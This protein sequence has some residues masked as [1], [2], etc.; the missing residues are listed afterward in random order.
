MPYLGWFPAI[1]GLFLLG[2]GLARVRGSARPGILAAS[3]PMALLSLAVVWF[4]GAREI[5]NGFRAIPLDGSP[6]LDTVLE[7]LEGVRVLTS[8]GTIGCLALLAAV[9][10][11][12]I[13]MLREPPRTKS[14][15]SGGRSTILVLGAT[16]SVIAGLG[17]GALG[18]RF[19]PLPIA[20]LLVDHTIDPQ[21]MPLSSRSVEG[22]DLAPD[23]LGRVTLE[24][25]TRVKNLALAATVALVVSVIG[26]VLGWVVTL[27]GS[28]SRWA[29]PGSLGLTA[30]AAVGSTLQARELAAL[31]HEIAFAQTTL[32]VSSMPKPRTPEPPGQ[33]IAGEPVKLV[34]L[35]GGAIRIE[36]DIAPPRKVKDASPVYP[37]EAVESRS[38]GTVVLEALIDSEGNVTRVKVLRSVPLLDQ[39]AIDAVK[40]WKYEPTIVEGVGVPVVNTVSVTF[41]LE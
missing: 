40:Q 21:A 20:I 7:T 4:L 22:L 3:I 32:A 33:D 31:K 29:L 38:E 10:L 24:L 9:G 36:G 25:A 2:L 19:F 1:A 37:R 6:Q 8:N 26:M 12:G 17:A 41:L 28:I 15:G 39:A 18:T 35:P 14:N 27:T 11:A 16:A 5:I 23:N 34:H 30:L 13:V